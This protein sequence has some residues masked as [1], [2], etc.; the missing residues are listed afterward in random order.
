MSD[1]SPQDFKNRWPYWDLT[2]TWCLWFDIEEYAHLDIRTSLRVCGH[3]NN[4]IQKDQDNETS[5][6]LIC[7][8]SHATARNT[9]Y[10]ASI[11]LCRLHE[12]VG[13]LHKDPYGFYSS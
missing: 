6:L 13:N 11:P 2:N 7:R 9:C 1:T 4:L 3:L 12:R 10:E 8:M 5:M